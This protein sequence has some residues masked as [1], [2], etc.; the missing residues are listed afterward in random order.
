MRAA[1]QYLAELAR[2]L[3]GVLPASGRP[4]DYAFLGRL[5]AVKLSNGFTDLRSRKIDGKDHGDYLFFR[6]RIQT[7]TPAKATLLGRTLPASTSISDLDIPFE[8]TPKQKSDFGQATRGK[9]LRF[10]PASCEV[11]IPRRLLTRRRS[12]LLAST[13]GAQAACAAGSRRR[14]S[15]A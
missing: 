11:N 5:P 10:A 2:E 12:R 4:Y 9:F 8:E 7:A 13:S 14:R 6:F 1:S 15:T 3:N